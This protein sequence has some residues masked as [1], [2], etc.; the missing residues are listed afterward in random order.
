MKSSAYWEDRANER[1][2]MYHK[3]SDDTVNVI[4]KTYDK[5][6]KDIQGEIKKIYDKFAVDGKLTPI[7]ARKILNSKIPIKELNNI[8]EQIKHIQDEDIKRQLLNKLNAPA[9]KARITRLEALKQDIYIKSKQIADVELRATTSQYIDTI[10]KAYY[11]HIFDIQKG[12]GVGFKVATMPSKTIEA[13]LKNPWSGKH[14]S[15]RIWNNTDILADQITEVITSGFKSGN[16]IDKMA[17]ELH[18]YTNYGKY[19]AERIVRTETTYMANSA[20]MESYKECEIDKYIF[21]ATLDMRTSNIC[22][23]LDRKVFDVNKS[24]PGVNRPPMHPHCRSTTR[25]Y[26]GDDTLKGIQRRARDPL[27][28][29]T[30]LIPAD[31]NYEQWY[32]KFAVGKYGQNKAKAMKN[33]ILNKTS[34][35]KQYTRYRNVLGKDLSVKSFE[36]FQ[37]LKY[38]NTEQW[39][40]L[41]GDY[42]KINAYNKIIANEPTITKDL[43]NISDITNTKMVGLKYRLKGKDS[44]LRKV[45]MDSNGSFSLDIINDT[46]S[47]TNDVIRY[48][49]QAKADKVVGKYFDI[50]KQLTNKGYKQIKVKNTWLAKGNPYKGINCNYKCPGGQ[51]F[52][53]QYHTPESFELKNGQ[54]HKLYEEWRVIENKASK[55]AIELSR[56]MS[57]LSSVLKVPSNIDKVR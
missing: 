24:T 57:K 15:E 21:V 54:L 38:N 46:I 51:S 8:R 32:Q 1:M 36:N 29:K 23:S 18:E 7:Q 11:K 20:E 2:A 34:D 14:F 5:A 56:K 25:A 40:A 48:T 39:N 44:Y 19:A 30:Y 45:D 17:R 27:T 55:E 12:I 37:D 33:M 50:N 42:R 4:T 31:K 41:K 10:N 43:K 22:Q 47:N 52:E 9:Y 28:G 26:L 49:Y 35:K 16:S 53:V 6:T 3:D 13:I